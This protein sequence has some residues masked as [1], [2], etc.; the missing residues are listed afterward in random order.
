MGQVKPEVVQEQQN[1]LLYTLKA[2]V[3]DKVWKYVKDYFYEQRILDAAL[4]QNLNY[5]FATSQKKAVICY[6]TT[7]Y[8]YDL[9]SNNIGRTQPYEVISI[10]KVLSD[11]GY[12]IDIV[13]C[14]DTKSLEHLKAKSYDLIFG[15][16][17]AFYQLTCLHPT[18][19]SILYM[20][21]HHPAFSFQEERKRLDYFRAR[22]NR[23]PQKL[24]SGIYY[25]LHHLEKTYSH[26]IT[27]GETE[28]FMLQYAKP[29]TIYPTGILNP[30]FDAE[31]RGHTSGRK[32][33]LWLGSTGA[34]HKGLDLL[35]DVFAE[36]NDIT[37][38]IAGLTQKDR[39]LLRVPS[40]AN[41]IDH[42]YI[43]IKSDAFRELAVTCSYIVLPSCSEGFS[44]AITTGMLHGLIPVVM[45]NTG[46]NRI[47]GY[48]V[49][50]DDFKIDYLKYKLLELAEKREEQL[51]E[52][53]KS[54]QAFARKNFS[55]TTFE[56]RLKEILLTTVSN[57][58]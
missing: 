44:T 31:Q 45:R 3:A 27:M 7:S 28:P 17:E 36:S 9:D 34:I 56:Q 46:F 10:V 24:R 15:F 50:L 32:N 13:G 12:C 20:T 39:K 18:A 2:K 58:D 38:H 55:I 30:Y 48:A 54:I 14:N 11:L 51:E 8:F 19:T 49:L 6:L 41:I 40:K 16:G 35:L 52:F 42:G 37:L 4:V 26:L 57:H 5:N 21:E 33:F 1:T 23:G 29:Y 47:E 53:S 25:K 43:D 22:H